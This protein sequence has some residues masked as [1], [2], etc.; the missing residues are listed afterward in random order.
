MRR[1]AFSGRQ[2]GVWQHLLA[3]AVAVTLT[4]LLAVLPA[5]GAPGVSRAF[6]DSG[7]SD[8]R[9]SV[10]AIR[11]VTTAAD[12]TRVVLR[13]SSRG[14][15][16]TTLARAALPP[17]DV[18]NPATDA[19][20]PAAGS[21]AGG[22][23]RDPHVNWAPHISYAPRAVT[24]PSP[25]RFP[26]AE[27]FT[28][29]QQ[30]SVLWK[31]ERSVPYAPRVPPTP[32]ERDAMMREEARRWAAAQDAKRPIP[33]GAVWSLFNPGADK[34]STQPQ[35][36]ALSPSPGGFSA[37]L[38]SP[39]AGTKERRRD[40][41]IHAGNLVRLQRLADRARARQDSLR[42]MDSIAMLTRP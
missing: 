22:S 2:T 33:V 25:G 41:A 31:L 17:A 39:G 15:A 27:T 21:R 26:G 3:L 10:E 18:G 34:K 30:D 42:R 8:T 5:I 16:R 20:K 12:D 23:D 29:E 36:T 40:S 13:D 1:F 11:F 7:D 4:A 37:P 14:A 32:A 28:A 9:V 6:Q 19:A 38:F 35:R 24:A